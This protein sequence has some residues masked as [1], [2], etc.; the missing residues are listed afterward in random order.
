MPGRASENTNPRDSRG[1]IDPQDMRN[2][3]NQASQDRRTADQLRSLMQQQGIKD[4]QNIDEYIKALA[5]L[6]GERAYGDPQGLQTLQAMALEKV[7]KVELDLRKRLDKTSDQ[8]FLNGTPD[9]PAASR[10]LVDEY[11]RQIGKKPGGGG[12]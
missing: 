3:R 8:M 11:F 12:K 6:E 7:Q 1:G 4:L 10:G 5:A 9:V 2:L